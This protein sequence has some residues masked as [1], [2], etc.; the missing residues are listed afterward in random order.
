M[1]TLEGCITAFEITPPSTDDRKGL[2]GIVEGQSGLVILGDKGCVG[3][4]L[5]REMSGQE[6][7]LMTIKQ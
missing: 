2:R 7:C 6:I 5:R 3:E 4:A 1:I